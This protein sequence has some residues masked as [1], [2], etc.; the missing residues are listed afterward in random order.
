MEK[1]DRSSWIFP[2]KC[3]CDLWVCFSFSLCTNSFCSLTVHTHA[4]RLVTFPSSSLVSPASLLPCKS[5]SHLLVFVLFSVPQPLTKAVCNLEFGTKH[6]SLVFSSV[7][8][9]LATLPPC[10]PESVT[11]RATVS[12]RTP[13]DPFL[14]HSWLLGQ[15]DIVFEFLLLFSFFPLMLSLF[16]QYTEHLGNITVFL[17]NE[18]YILF[19]VSEAQLHEEPSGNPPCLADAESGYESR[20]VWCWWFPVS[21][22]L[23]GR[24]IFRIPRM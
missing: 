13:L 8:I 20:S 15:C 17:Q 6:Q 22:T 4:T 18:R 3:I 23:D 5:F 19:C 16:P 24:K 21:K 11:N 12:D 7:G 2:W 10:L 1:L 9:H 14:L